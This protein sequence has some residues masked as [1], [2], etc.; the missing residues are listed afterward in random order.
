M[1]L[2]RPIEVP[3]RRTFKLI[4]GRTELIARRARKAFGLPEA[5]WRTIGTFGG[6]QA[7]PC[8]RIVVLP[9]LDF[10]DQ[11]VVNWIENIVRLRLVP[12]GVMEVLS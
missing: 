11:M 6:L 4:V 5:E 3:S 1:S 2:D 12:G 9:G 7:L 10:D 8:E